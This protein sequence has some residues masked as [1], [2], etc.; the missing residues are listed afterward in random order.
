VA[1]QIRLTKLNKQRVKAV[2]KNEEATPTKIAN[3]LIGLAYATFFDVSG[4]RRITLLPRRL[5]LRPTNC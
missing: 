4:R 1:V 2:A 5:K 3:E